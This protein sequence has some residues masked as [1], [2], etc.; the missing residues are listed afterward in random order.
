[1]IKLN[2]PCA[3]KELVKG[4]DITKQNCKEYEAHNADYK[5]G[6]R[7][8]NFE[9]NI[10]GHNAVRNLLKRIQNEKCCFC[11]GKFGAYA[12]GDVEHYRPKGAVRQND[13]STATV[14]GYF[15]LAYSW[16][17]LYWCC[18]VCN[19]S[20]KRDYFPLK[21]PSKRA[22]SHT[23]DLT[24]EEPLILDPGGADDPRE[25][26]GFHQELAIGLTD[27][28]KSTIRIVGL[29][30][31][32]LLEDRLVRLSEIDTLL[33]IIEISES[34]PNPQIAELSEQANGTLQ[35]AAFPLA[36]FSAMATDYLNKRSQ[37]TSRSAE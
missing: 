18:Q 30:R 11:E 15:W 2:K 12:S 21:D 36:T 19:R 25:H 32:E 29:N 34:E 28:G 24:K 31:A 35:A 7:K 22:R 9:R 14:P 8:F 13:E 37:L 27:I 1:M 3:P 33:K 4:E 5:D 26:I 23:D 6:S 16:D 10:Y 17:N 20:N